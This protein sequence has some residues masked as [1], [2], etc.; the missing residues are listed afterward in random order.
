MKHNN[1]KA[2]QN[3]ELSEYELSPDKVKISLY[4]DTKINQQNHE[5]PYFL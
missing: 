5:K 2:I 1:H 4:T 3:I